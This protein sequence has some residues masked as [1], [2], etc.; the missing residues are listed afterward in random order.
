MDPNSLSRPD[1]CVCKH[2]HFKLDVLFENQVV[3]GSLRIT[4]INLQATNNQLILDS[5]NLHV[6]SVKDATSKELLHFELLQAKDPFGSALVI[7]L[8]PLTARCT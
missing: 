8:P 6:L 5:N 4:A 7:E 2:L 3:T 1:L